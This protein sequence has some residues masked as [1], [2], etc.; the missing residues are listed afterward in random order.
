MENMPLQVGVLDLILAALLLLFLV[1]GLVRGIVPELGGVLSILL[2]VLA[3]GSGTLHNK[4][5]GWYDALLPDPGWSDLAA[6]VSVFLAVFIIARML[7]QILERLASEKAPGWLD[8][9]LGG[10]A[11]FIKGLLACTIILVCLAY[12]APESNFRKSSLLAPYFNSFWSQVSE[13]TG[14]AHRLPRL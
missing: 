5:A 2:A 9:G 14:G 12:L 4:V 1:R 6:Y 10:L 13:L 7:F 3:S 11:G 8:R